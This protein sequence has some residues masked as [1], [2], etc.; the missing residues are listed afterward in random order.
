MV[1]K[2]YCAVFLNAY[3]LDFMPPKLMASKLK[4]NEVEGDMRPGKG[5]LS[6][7]GLRLVKNN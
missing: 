6:E 2:R 5:L 1:C 7:M 4:Q 3:L